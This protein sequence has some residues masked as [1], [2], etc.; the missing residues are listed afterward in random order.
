LGHGRLGSCEDRL[1]EDAPNRGQPGDEPSKV[2]AGG[3]EDGVG[4]VA[5]GAFEEVAAHAVLAL[6]LADDGFDGRASPQFALDGVVTRRL[7]PA[8]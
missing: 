8:I 4:G 7:W 3:G 5:V 2:V 1:D 6:G